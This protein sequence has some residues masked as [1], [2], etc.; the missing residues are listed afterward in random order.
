MRRLTVATAFVAPLAAT[1]PAVAS[2]AAF[3]TPSVD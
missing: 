2:D 3:Q 1:A